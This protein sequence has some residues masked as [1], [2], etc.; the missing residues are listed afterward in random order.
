MTSCPLCSIP[1]RPWPQAHRCCIPTS[2]PFA[3]VGGKGSPMHV[4]LA[5]FL[6]R[7]AKRPVRIVLSGTEDLQAGNPRHPAWVTIRT[8]LTRDGQITA[9][10]VRAV[11]A[12]GAY[13]GYKPIAN[14][15]LAG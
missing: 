3:A 15:E 14:A 1:S 2:P 13:A 7:A 11:F 5:Y 12:S 4:P 8:G 10:H 9:R 6:S